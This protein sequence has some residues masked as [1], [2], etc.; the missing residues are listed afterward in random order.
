M[1]QRICRIYHL[2]ILQYFSH[3]RYIYMFHMNL[4]HQLKYIRN[5]KSYYSPMQSLVV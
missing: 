4:Y 5:S 2:Q 3:Y 1:L